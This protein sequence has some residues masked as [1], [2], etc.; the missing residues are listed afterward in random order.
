M[1]SI[2]RLSAV[3]VI[4]AGALAGALLLKTSL[5]MPMVLAAGLAAATALLYVPAAIRL[6]TPPTRTPK[7][8]N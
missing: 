6:G 2:R 1:D 3:L 4:L 8:L 7:P 5:V